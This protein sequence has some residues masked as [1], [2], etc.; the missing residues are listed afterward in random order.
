MLQIPLKATLRVNLVRGVAEHDRVAIE[1]EANLVRGRVENNIQA[2]AAR[3]GCVYVQDQAADRTRLG[4]HASRY[5]REGELFLGN[6]GG[7]LL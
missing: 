1:R 2:H 5:V 6:A 7:I 3:S 4:R